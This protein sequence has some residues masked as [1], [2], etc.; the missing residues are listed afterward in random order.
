M[1]LPLLS[2]PLFPFTAAAVHRLRDKFA[3]D[4]LAAELGCEVTAHPRL[5]GR[6]EAWDPLP[7][8]RLVTGTPEDVRAEVRRDGLRGWLAVLGRQGQQ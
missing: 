6:V 1:M 5:A 2:D 4:R 7:G 3:A 8:L